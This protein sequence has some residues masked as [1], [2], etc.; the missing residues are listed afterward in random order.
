MHLV[1][2]PLSADEV[3]DYYEGF[4]NDTLWPLYHDVIVQPRAT[5]ATGGDAY[6]EVNQRFA[7]AVAEEAA[8]GATR[9][10]ARLP[11]A[12]GPGDAPRAAPRPADRLV[13]P[14]PVPGRRALRPAA[15]AAAGPRRAA[16]RR[17]PRLPARAGRPQLPARLPPRCSACTTAQGHR[18]DA[19]PTARARACAPARIPISIDSAGLEALARSP[20]G[21]STARPEIRE[22]LGDP[23]AVLL[24][25]DRL[26]YT[27]GI[28]HRL[29][30]YGELLG[31]RHDR[32]ARHRAGAGGDAEPRA[33]RRRT[34]SC[35]SEIELTVGRDQRR[36]R[37]D[38]LA[39][40]STTCTTPTRAT[41]M[42]A[43]YQAADVM[44]VTPLRDGMNLVA[45]EYVTCRHD[46]GGA[47]V[48][49]RVHR[50]RGT[51]C[52]RR[53]S[54]TRTTSRASSR[55][56]SRRST[57]PTHEQRRRRMRALRRRVRGPRR[58]PLGRPV[59]RR[60]RVAPWRPKRI[61][62]EADRASD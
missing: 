5:T 4:S 38:R 12:A 44:L 60:P 2:V 45:K 16:R 9:L 34:A 22:E 54:A 10:G 20:G 18:D 48:L 35:A 36:V 28:R 52:T 37:H 58:A 27:K 40:R 42:A 51:S 53:S 26:D 7:E 8:E 1:P 61:H 17:L 46:G 31:R 49:S 56:S 47:L 25:V 13:Q 6:V 21:A 43:L 15:V 59:P 3:A 32:P 50:R 19:G 30:A 33:R 14:H 23:A 11:A 39:A 57:P 55:R 62:A 29:K 41:E 24:G